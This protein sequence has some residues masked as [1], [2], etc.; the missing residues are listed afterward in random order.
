M[1]GFS[2]VEMTEDDNSAAD[3]VSYE[4]TDGTYVLLHSWYI[5]HMYGCCCMYRYSMYVCIVIR[6]RINRVRLPN[7]LVVS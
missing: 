3:T 2:L 7:L 5:I 6:V 4:C 1:R